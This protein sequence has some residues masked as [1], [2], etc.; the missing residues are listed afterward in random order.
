MVKHS[1]VSR[2]LWRSPETSDLSVDSQLPH[3][4]P[5][6]SVSPQSAFIKMKQKDCF[7]GIMGTP[8]QA[9]IMCAFPIGWKT[10]F[11]RDADEGKE[12][13]KHSS[14]ATL[15]AGCSSFRPQSP[16]SGGG[17]SS[18]LPSGWCEP[19]SA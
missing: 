2:R 4:R 11:S 19:S 10:E 5:F 12:E 1:L 14:V 6:L 16:S 7:P 17:S 18:C 9:S 13:E 3:Q 8:Q 15:T